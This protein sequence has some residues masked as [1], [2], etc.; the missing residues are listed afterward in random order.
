MI[1]GRLF[2]GELAPW[3]S[4]SR[5][6]ENV[7]LFFFLPQQRD[8]ESTLKDLCLISSRRRTIAA[9]PSTCQ[10]ALS[11]PWA[12]T[13]QQCSVQ[14][15]LQEFSKQTPDC[16]PTRCTWRE[17][18][19]PRVK[20]ALIGH[21]VLQGRDCHCHGSRALLGVIISRAPANLTTSGLGVLPQGL[22]AHEH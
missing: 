1:V 18:F 12:S 11:E 19:V 22:C 5:E 9:L 17:R 8:A 6:K 15:R 3:C 4:H 13:V 20:A 10:G 7:P 14:G 16:K 2:L 21:F